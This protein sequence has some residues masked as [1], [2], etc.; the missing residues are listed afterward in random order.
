MLPT[1]VQ[2]NN[3]EKVQCPSG[4]LPEFADHEISIMNQCMRDKECIDLHKQLEE[5]IESRLEYCDFPLYRGISQIELDK[6]CDL[7]PGDKFYFNRVTSFSLDR[8]IAAEFSNTYGYGTRV[9]LKLESGHLA[10]PYSSKQCI[11]LE[12]TP[13]IEYMINRKLNESSA[14]LKRIEDIEMVEREQ[15]WMVSGSMELEIVSIGEDEFPLG[16]GYA[17]RTVYTVRIVK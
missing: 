4:H 7:Y 14:R 9:I 12:N 15:E 17:K 2:E 11:I 5:L 10:F 8:E 1:S 16:I 6:I 13:D 3:M